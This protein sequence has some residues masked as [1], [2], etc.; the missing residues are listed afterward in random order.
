MCVSYMVGNE[1]RDITLPTKVRLIKAMVFWVV[2]YGCES[3]T[4][5]KAERRRTDAFDWTVV[6]EKTLASPLEYKEIKPVHPKGNQSWIFIG[7]TEAEAA[8]PILWPPGGEEL[9]HCKRTWRWARLKAEGKGDDRG[10][11]GWMAS[12]THDMSLGGLRELVMDREAWC[13]AV[14]GVAKSRTQLNDWTEL[15]WE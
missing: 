15:N 3:W 7:R 5:K 11:D 9:S 6:L 13:A 2:M 8:T 12:P 10:S 14:H 1:P 4:I